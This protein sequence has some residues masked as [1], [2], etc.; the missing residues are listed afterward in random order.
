MHFHIGFFEFL[1]VGLYILAWNAIFHF[2]NVEARR[3][4]WKTV[5]G[6]SGLHS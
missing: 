1:I 2:V 5:A 3:M 4:G 6:V